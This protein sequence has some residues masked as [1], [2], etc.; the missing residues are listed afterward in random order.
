MGE[1]VLIDAKQV[2]EI[3]GWANSN[4]H[5]KIHT[6]FRWAREHGKPFPFRKFKD[7][8]GRVRYDKASVEAYAAARRYSTRGGEF[9]TST[10]REVT[11]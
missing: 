5:T 11:E 1:M 10:M 4:P 6:A 9:D 2:A 7:A 3:L 8:A